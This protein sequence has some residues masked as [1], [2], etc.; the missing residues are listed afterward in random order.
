MGSIQL[1]SILM[2]EGAMRTTVT[3]EEGVMEKLMKYTHSNHQLSVL[4]LDKHFDHIHQVKKV[5]F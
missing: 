3:V 4:T 5:K 2:M 1:M